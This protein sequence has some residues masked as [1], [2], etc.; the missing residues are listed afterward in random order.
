MNSLLLQDRSVSFTEQDLKKHEEL[1]AA[2]CL[3]LGA[4]FYPQGLKRFL[5]AYLES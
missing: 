3:V 4:W 5:S 1:D 2:W